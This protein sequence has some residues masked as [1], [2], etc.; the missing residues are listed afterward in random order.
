AAPPAANAGPRRA[1]ILLAEDHHVNQE[2]ALAMLGNLGYSADVAQNG[3]EAV[4][5]WETHPVDL[6]LMDCQMPVMDGYTATRSI[7]A[8]EAQTGRARTPIVALTANAVTG[9]REKC[10]AAGMDDYLSK[11][12]KASQLAPMLEQ[13]LPVELHA[14][15]MA[16][17]AAATVAASDVRA[18]APVTAAPLLAASESSAA[19]IDDQALA[20]I[21]ACQPPGAPSLLDKII[22]L[23]LKD[24]P[25]LIDDLRQAIAGNDAEAVF[26]G[27]HALKNI[28]AN[29]GATQVSE[30]SRQLESMGRAGDVSRAGP[31]LSQLERDHALAAE[32]LKSVRSENAG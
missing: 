10:L 12:F 7:R 1:R 4:A 24:S 6:I 2:V 22:G 18:P 32:R 31:L 17:P 19:V 13:W 5:K 21:R 25:P 8:R 3:Q 27:A 26:R 16:V 14:G 11:P 23:Y 28:S 30:L 29:L 9:D 20:A 15:A